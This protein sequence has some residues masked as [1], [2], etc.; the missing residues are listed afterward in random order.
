MSRWTGARIT[1]DIVR[2]WSPFL[3]D[4]C[5]VG[6]E[7][8]TRINREIFLTH[9]HNDHLPLPQVL[10]EGARIHVASPLLS[11][12]QRIYQNR[13]I[14]EEYTDYIETEHTLIVNNRV[15]SV[16]AYCYFV[17][18]AIVI[19]EADN[20]ADLVSEYRAK[21]VFLFVFKQPRAHL[22]NAFDN[23]RDDLFLLDVS[24]WQPYRPNVIPK[25]T[26]SNADRLQYQMIYGSKVIP[27]QM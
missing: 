13:A 7:M 2:R 1:Q 6:R 10:G 17:N 4:V 27:Y 23:C 16:P 8:A 25:I 12:M 15:A 9:T 11:R 21:Y 18:D 22:G 19:P 5:G 14:I 24:V 26:F 20:A 3:F